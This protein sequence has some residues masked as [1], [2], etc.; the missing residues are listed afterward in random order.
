L[1]LCHTNSIRIRSRLCTASARLLAFKHL[2]GVWNISSISAA[3]VS[4]IRNLSNANEKT[5]PGFGSRRSGYSKP[6]AAIPPNKDDGGLHPHTFRRVRPLFQKLQYLVHIGCHRV[7][8]VHLTGCRS[9]SRR[10]GTCNARAEGTCIRHILVIAGGVWRSLRQFKSVDIWRIET[11]Y[12]F[13][14]GLNAV[15]CA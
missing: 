3:A 6:I 12:G 15:D 4:K 1:D 8:P 2:L 11:R 13:L 5:R 10:C 14:P 9:K 7:P